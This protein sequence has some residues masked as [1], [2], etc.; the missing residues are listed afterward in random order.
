[1]PPALSKQYQNYTC[2]D[3]DKFQKQIPTKTRSIEDSVREYVQE[4]LLKDTRW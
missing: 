1:M 4:Y 2:A 3:M